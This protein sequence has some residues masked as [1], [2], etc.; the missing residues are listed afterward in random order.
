[1][2]LMAQPPGGVNNYFQAPNLSARYDKLVG[3]RYANP[4]YTQQL[5]TETLPN[6]QN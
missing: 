2:R 1:M 5:M 6:E 4:T 3:L